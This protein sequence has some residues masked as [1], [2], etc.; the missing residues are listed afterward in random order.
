MSEGALNCRQCEGKFGPAIGGEFC[1][2]CQQLVQLAGH[3]LSRRFPSARGPAA[4]HLLRDSYLRLLDISEG[5]WGERETTEFAKPPGESPTGKSP[6]AEEAPAEKRVEVKQ[7]LKSASPV[8]EPPGLSG[9]AAP[10]KPPKEREES[11]V[12]PELVRTEEPQ[13]SRGD[14]QAEGRSR[15]H[16]RKRKKKSKSSHRRSRSKRRRRRGAREKEESPRP[17]PREEGSGERAEEDKGRPG[18]SS[19]EE[20]LWREPRPPSR[21]PPRRDYSGYYQH[22][23]WEGPILARGGDRER[24][25]RRRSPKY[26]NK[27]NKK[28]QQ[29][30]RAKGKGGWGKGRRRY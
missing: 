26:T 10:V 29:Q 22:P 1:P 4:L 8:K 18:P 19:V 7:E 17:E 23:V 9:K 3:L 25:F 28:K 27:G 2:V 16:P 30:E 13:S 14:H 11:R 15:S 21:S 5:F 20:R 6:K 12:S 24:D